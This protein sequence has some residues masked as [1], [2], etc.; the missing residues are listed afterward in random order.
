MAI[1]LSET[2]AQIADAAHYQRG[3]ECLAGFLLAQL[4]AAGMRPGQ[5]LPA[6]QEESQ[7]QLQADPDSPALWPFLRLE[8]QLQALAGQPVESEGL[9]TALAERF[10]RLPGAPRP[11]LRDVTAQR[12]D[13]PTGG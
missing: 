12:G 1:N 5:L 4:A 9:P 8:A 10:P 11:R 6:L 7:G 3:L 13:T 2:A